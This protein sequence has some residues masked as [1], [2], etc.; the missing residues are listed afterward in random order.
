MKNITRDIKKPD[1]VN[2]MPLTKEEVEVMEMAEEWVNK[3]IKDDNIEK[4][5][6]LQEQYDKA[7]RKS[8]RQTKA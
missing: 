7:I 4:E 3:I 1:S 5:Q 8:R 6:K 2:D